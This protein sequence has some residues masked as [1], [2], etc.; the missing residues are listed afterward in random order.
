MSETENK[1]GGAKAPKRKQREVHLIRSEFRKLAV[2]LSETIL[3][4]GDYKPDG[5]KPK[6]LRVKYNPLYAFMKKHCET[7]F[8]HEFDVC[9]MF[10]IKIHGVD[11]VNG[12]A[13]VSFEYESNQTLCQYK[14]KF[15][16]HLSPYSE[17]WPQALAKQGL[18]GTEK[19][20]KL[21]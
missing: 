13:E 7:I 19:E 1:K 20:Y 6:Q 14:L 8:E 10:G 11:L 9:L 4:C 12:V 15:H 16:N 18:A 21:V 17:V 5:D 2:L 3:H